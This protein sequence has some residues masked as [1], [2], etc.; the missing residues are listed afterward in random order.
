MAI[1]NDED[2]EPADDE[3][4][5]PG[6]C[7]SYYPGVVYIIIY[8]V[9]SFLVIVNMYIAVIL[10][11]YTQVQFNE[12]ETIPYFI[13]FSQNLTY[14]CSVLMFKTILGSAQVYSLSCNKQL[15]DVLGLAN[16]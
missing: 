13:K 4:G 6:D 11:N 12:Y 14:D 16:M 7:G 9:F 8:L 2:C 5:L 3:L 1:A 15:Q 10:E